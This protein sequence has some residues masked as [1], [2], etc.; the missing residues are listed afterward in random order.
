[1]LKYQGVKQL[2]KPLAELSKERC[3]KIENGGLADH[4]YPLVKEVDE[5]D[6]NQRVNRQRIVR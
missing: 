4:S 3:G 5:K 6:Y 1:M 2:V